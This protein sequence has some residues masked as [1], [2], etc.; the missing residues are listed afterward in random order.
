MV[1][2]YIEPICL[3]ENL[4]TTSKVFYN[5]TSY[6]AFTCIGGGAGC[7]GSSGC[8]GGGRLL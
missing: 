8:S 3:Y 6:N 4:P 5:V 2:L 1:G 7:T